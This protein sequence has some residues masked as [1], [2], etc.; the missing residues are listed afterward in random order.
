MPLSF[1]RTGS[2]KVY[3]PTYRSGISTSSFNAA[4]NSA[5]TGIS[6]RSRNYGEFD[7][8]QYAKVE[9]G[10]ADLNANQLISLFVKAPAYA[11]EAPLRPADALLG[12]IPG[13]VAGGIQE[14]IGH[15]PVLNTIVGGAG[16]IL[17]QLDYAGSSI[18]NMYLARQLQQS[19]GKPDYFVIG[20]NTAGEVRRKAMERWGFDMEGNQYSLAQLEQRAMENPLNF[21]Q[22][23]TSED[24]LTDFVVRSALNPLNALLIPGVAAAGIRGTAAGAKYLADASQAARWARPVLKATTPVAA[25]F[26]FGYGY[27]AELG[28]GIGKAYDAAHNPNWAERLFPDVNNAAKDVVEGN[29]VRSGYN[30][31]FL[32]AA[33]WLT[34][35]T[36]SVGRKVYFPGLNTELKGARLAGN[37]AR[38]WMRGGV[39]QGVAGIGAEMF[40]GGLD[41]YLDENNMDN[42]V[43]GGTINTL[44]D[45]LSKVNNSHPLS[46]HD[47]FVLAAM[48]LPFSVAARE[49]PSPLTSKW[50]ASRLKNYGNSVAAQVLEREKALGSTH[51][52]VDEM[53]TFLGDGDIER[54]RNAMLWFTEYAEMEKASN[55]LGHL[56]HAIAD[57]ETDGMAMR[58]YFIGGILREDVQTRRAIGALD[59]RSTADYMYDLHKSAGVEPGRIKPSEAGK[60]RGLASQVT[61]VADSML[62][63]IKKL[64]RAHENLAP[65]LEELGL[66]ITRGGILT[67]EVMESIIAHF[68]KT[69]TFDRKLAREIL[70]MGPSLVYD[71]PFMREFSVTLGQK[72]KA[73]VTGREISEAEN[74]SREELR[75]ALVEIRDRTPSQQEAM[76]ETIRMAK[77]VGKVR[78]G[79]FQVKEPPYPM[80]KKM[81]ANRNKHTGRTIVYANNDKK[82]TEMR[83]TEFFKNGQ[84]K[85]DTAEEVTSSRGMAYKRQSNGS[86]AREDGVGVN[87]EDGAIRLTIPATRDSELMAELDKTIFKTGPRKGQIKPGME[88]LSQKLNLDIEAARLGL[89]EDALLLATEHG[90]RT[91]VAPVGAGPWLADRGYVE[92]AR[93]EHKYPGWVD[94]GEKPVPPEPIAYD[95]PETSG[96]FEADGAWVPDGGPLE[97]DG[98]WSSYDRQYNRWQRAMREGVMRGDISEAEAT[99]RGFDVN[100][101][102]SQRIEDRQILKNAPDILYHATTDIKGI[103]NK[104]MLPREETGNKGLG[105]GPADLVS[106]TDDPLVAKRIADVYIEAGQIVRGEKP[107]SELAKIAKDNDFYDWWEKASSLNSKE[108]DEVVNKGIYKADDV[109]SDGFQNGTLKLRRVKV[110]M[111]PDEREELRL[112]LYNKFL[113][114]QG[115]ATG[116]MDPVMVATD[117]KK[118]RNW[119]TDNVGIVRAQ[120]TSGRVMGLNDETEMYL[121]EWKMDP[122]TVELQGISNRAAYSF[123]GGDPNKILS[124]KSAGAMPRY[125]P[126]KRIERT[127]RAAIGVARFDA[128]RASMLLPAEMAVGPAMTSAT[129][130]FPED[131]FNTLREHIRATRNRYKMELQRTSEMD[132]FAMS[133]LPFDRKI[134]EMNLRDWLDRPGINEL[135]KFRELMQELEKYPELG[136]AAGPKVI[137]DPAADR[138]TM[139]QS[140]L[141]ARQ[142]LL[143]DYGSAAPIQRLY[144]ALLAPKHARWL[145]KQAQDEVHNQLATVGWEPGATRNFM[146]KVRKEVLDSRAVVGL[147]KFTGAHRWPTIQAVPED[148]LQALAREIS[149]VHAQAVIDKY[150]SFQHMITQAA[151]RMLR[152]TE[153]AARSGGKV[154]KIEAAADAAFR[155]WQYAPGF[156]G[157]SGAG[158]RFTK[159]TYPALRFA[160]D[161][162]FVVMNYL[163]PYTYNILNNGWR[164]RKAASPTAERLS[165][166]ASAGNIPPG[167]LYSEKTPS[168]LLLADPGFYTIPRNIA[169]NLKSEFGLKTQ[170]AAEQYFEAMGPEHPIALMM[171]ERFGDNIK[172]WASEFNDMMASLVRKGPEHTTRAAWK[173]TLEDELG[174]T[175]A[176]MK[177]L[178][179]VVERL[180]EKYR[181]I[182]NDLLNLYV[183][184]MSRSNIERFANNFF[185]FWP[186]SYMV[187]VTGWAY[188]VLMEKLGPVQ[189]NAGAFLWDEYRK[190]YEQ[191]HD[192]D[193]DFRQWTEDNPDFLFALEML[194][195][196][197]PASIGVSLSRPT[198]YV[199]N[200]V[201]DEWFGKSGLFGDYKPESVTDLAEG[202]TRFG[203][204]RTWNMTNNILKSFGVPGFY[205]EPSGNRPP[206]ILP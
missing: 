104:G 41:A 73:G 68:D 138:F 4:I 111:S 150:G 77:S 46:D 52:N 157:L 53:L 71:N 152:Q 185:M 206:A 180:T 45:I 88:A 159:F 169:P 135:T 204:I 48:F 43:I 67:K 110:D 125:R 145:G 167:G 141:N 177:E 113:R 14:V 114:T 51:K 19:I 76:H 106:F 187:K 62:T 124:N 196:I 8:G 156:R 153:R 134:T 193:A 55:Q 16:E 60:E 130:M 63:E 85:F 87:I 116:I 119:T 123:Q 49:I 47:G 31:S 154:N 33:S 25:P 101:W 162:L 57:A 70:D 86:Y 12:G 136:L 20:N 96:H 190:R 35:G 30:Q 129:S 133:L 205:S 143:T 149:P 65:Q 54:G 64:Y 18:P 118:V 188:K 9:G 84:R 178:A 161:P 13:Q 42:T 10:R 74:I 29:L 186:I 80:G 61:P 107:L 126:T 164:G 24:G 37:A 181:G 195:P 139:F 189:G 78:Q 191:L 131:R 44:H 142:R 72:Q 92:S 91:F 163:E 127:E 192:N 197:T 137:V 199:G 109:E 173:K 144:D 179:P 182:H 69:D 36:L 95:P 184:R 147:G 194:M 155:F 158:Q 160:A 59:P 112:A 99:A 3:L 38:A 2:P 22:F 56:T 79:M 50:R 201:A 151:N 26:R 27:A 122:S 58:N 165:E 23:P 172:D 146:A 202:S 98:E 200:W 6:D 93:I 120:P 132:E 175:H 94:P 82:F 75:A 121:K 148:K 21:G 198:R 81:E 83:D 97:T 171:R 28:R 183:G 115:S 32:T 90:G 103:R 140:T 34:R 66:S 166:L 39:Q 203:P 108:F 117:V 168:E 170:K 1:A 11:L 174:W 5:Y 17:K 40:T 105:G 15:I 128:R 7:P 89:D 102:R 176:Q 100:R